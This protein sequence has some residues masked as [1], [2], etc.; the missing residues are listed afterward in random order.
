MRWIYIHVWTTREVEIA[1]QPQ[2]E[3]DLIAMAHFA[4]CI[5]PANARHST[6]GLGSYDLDDL[7]TV[8]NRVADFRITSYS[9]PWLSWHSKTMLPACEKGLAGLY[10]GECLVFVVDAQEGTDRAS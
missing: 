9:I 2:T 8:F 3:L 10:A 6:G 7:R 4:F 1:S 5:D